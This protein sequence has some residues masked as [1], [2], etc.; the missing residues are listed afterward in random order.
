MGTIAE[1]AED[2][3]ILPTGRVLASAVLEQVTTHSLGTF[4]DVDRRIGA[5]QGIEISGI[6]RLLPMVNAAISADLIK[7]NEEH[8]ALEAAM[9]GHSW[10]RLDGHALVGSWPVDPADW[11]YEK[12]DVFQD[13]ATK[14]PLMVPLSLIDEGDEITVIL[15]KSREPN[16]VRRIVED[17]YEP[18]LEAV[19]EESVS[20]RYD[21]KMASL[22][23]G[24]ARNL[25]KQD[26]Y[27]LEKI[28]EWG[29][30]EEQVRAVLT[31]ARDV[32]HKRHLDAFAWLKTWGDEWNR[33]QA[34]PEA[35]ERN[36][37]PHPAAYVRAWEEWYRSM[38]YF[39]LGITE[40]P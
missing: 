10:I 6:S 16:I 37:N 36:A 39:P 30:P 23:L 40:D 25:E 24:D 28:I 12:Q 5:V 9:N 11:A 4:R 8:V 17:E 34:S 31:V 13:L 33:A 22:L 15:G 18:S 3:D 20:E 35:P 21:P 7:N 2:E 32:N 27:W 29:P 14:G 38:V 19:I 1:F 26:V